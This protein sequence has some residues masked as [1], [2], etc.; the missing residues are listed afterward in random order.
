MTNKNETPFFNNVH[1]K[2]ILILFFS[3]S[4]IFLGE[5]KI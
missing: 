5:M 1:E 3:F 4:Y 2:Y